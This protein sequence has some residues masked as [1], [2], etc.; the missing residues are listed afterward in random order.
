MEGSWPKWPM[1]LLVR[2]ALGGLASRSILPGLCSQ[3]LHSPIGRGLHTV[4]KA[5]MIRFPTE[6]GGGRGYYGQRLDNRSVNALELSQSV[7]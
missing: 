5:R 3:T 7:Q 2:A 4:G 1:S 6:R